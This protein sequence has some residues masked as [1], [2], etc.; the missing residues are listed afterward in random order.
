MLNFL[1]KD[2][3]QVRFVFSVSL[4]NIIIICIFFFISKHHRNF[5]EYKNSVNYYHHE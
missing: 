3:L 5:Y 4:I 1:E 2:N